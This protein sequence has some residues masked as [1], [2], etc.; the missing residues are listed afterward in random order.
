MLA[1]P[2]KLAPSIPKAKTGAIEFVENF[3]N[4][5]SGKYTDV[6]DEA[7]QLAARDAGMS[8]NSGGQAF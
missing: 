8:E 7:F 6:A 3:K 5:S 4:V 2:W 1:S